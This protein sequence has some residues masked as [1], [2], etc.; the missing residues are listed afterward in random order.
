MVVGLPAAALA[1]MLGL[2][3]VVNAHIFGWPGV[4]GGIALGAGGIGLGVRCFRPR[5]TS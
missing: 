3:L 5:S 4:V 2:V 1:V